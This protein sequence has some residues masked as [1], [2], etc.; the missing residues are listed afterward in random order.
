MA[1][2]KDIESVNEVIATYADLNFKK[3]QPFVTDVEEEYI[4]DFLGETMY[5]A[6]AIK[7]TY[8]DDEL[9]LVKEIGKPVVTLAMLKALPSLNLGIS[10]QGLVVTNSEKLAPA[11]Q[12]RTEDLKRSLL[13][14]GHK[15]LD[16]LL[17]FIDANKEKDAY[18][19]LDQSAIY[20]SHC[21]FLPNAAAF[22]KHVRIDKSRYLYVKML[23]E[24]LEVESST[25]KEILGDT[26]YDELILAYKSEPGLSANQLKLEPY[27]ASIIAHLA[28]AESLLPLGI[29][30]DDRGVTLF[31]SN[32]SETV[33]I[34][35][36]VEEGTIQSLEMRH[37]SKAQKKIED[38]I[39]FL[40]KNIDDYSSFTDSDK[41]SDVNTG[42]DVPT[43]A[44]SRIFGA[45]EGGF[46]GL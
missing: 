16:A 39:Q 24:I 22:D 14:M 30:V 5:S 1:I 37:R 20:S 43:S 15:R 28:F 44:G 25:V 41:Y 27:C 45:D 40:H 32:H 23:P 34:A 26:L 36:P 19:D 21:Y 33:N 4:I 2:V 12:N 17:K 10:A 31:N 3:I 42:E 18:S 35:K 8:E 9:E 38:L 7:E 46:V 6:L 11:S 13:D 29:Q